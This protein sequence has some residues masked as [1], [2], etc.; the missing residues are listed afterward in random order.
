LAK[1][2]FAQGHHAGYNLDQT[3]LYFANRGKKKGEKRGK[4]VAIVDLK[5]RKLIKTV[6]SGYGAGHV[7]ASPEGKLL[8][9]NVESL[10]FS[11]EIKVGD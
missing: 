3:R 10:T 2:E 8:T 1:G 6:E 7:N 4:T 9:I 11:K 5:E